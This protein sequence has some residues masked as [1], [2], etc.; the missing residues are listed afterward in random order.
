MQHYRI[1][2]N[3][4][5]LHVVDRGEGP[6]VLLCHGFPAIWS[7]WRVQMEAL[8]EAGYRV[9][10]PD[11][12]GY[13]ESDAPE[14]AEAYTPFHTVGDLVGVLDHFGLVN[15][16][17]VGHDF[18]ANVA[19]NAA[20]LR[21]DRF[22]AV[23][24]ISVPFLLPVSPSF[25]DGLRAAGKDDFYM[26]AQI[27]AEADERWAAATEP[28]LGVTYWTSGLAPDGERWDAFDPAGG[29]LRA[30]PAHLVGI[31]PTYLREATESFARTGFHGPLNYY[32]AIDPFYAAVS[33]TFAGSVIR[34][35]SFYLAGVLDG[36]D[37]VRSVTEDDLRANL[38]GLRGFVRLE[39]VG[40]WPQ[41][42]APAAV[43]D[44]LVAFLDDAIP[45][46]R[47]D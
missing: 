9:F 46:P 25:L 31:D 12:R 30:A 8:A 1:G 4:I 21:P 43:N 33:G 42:E 19:W 16:A 17:V 29:L 18:G 36:L 34:Q 6:A 15:A 13:G 14:A 32:R 39:G 40:H 23:F 10:V 26:F 28:V 20:L 2:T 7:S 11:M 5:A 27:Q 44:A 38:P 45:K 47:P 35:P 24:G 41:L 3:G 22:S 37:R